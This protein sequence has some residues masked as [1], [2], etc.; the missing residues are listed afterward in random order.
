MKTN[1]MWTVS[2]FVISLLHIV[3]SSDSSEKSEKFRSF[4]LNIEEVVQLNENLKEDLHRINETNKKLQADNE[5]LRTDLHGIY[6]TNQALIADNIV[7]KGQ[8]AE[9]NQTT[10]ISNLQLRLAGKKIY[11]SDYHPVVHVMAL[12]MH[13]L[14]GITTLSTKRHLYCRVPPRGSKLR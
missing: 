12:L 3:Q 4:L 7:L 13:P 11:Q 2:M 9:M 8:G 6:E 10:G 14:S 5:A 1:I